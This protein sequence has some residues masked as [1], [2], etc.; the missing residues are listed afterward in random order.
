MVN[1]M[2]K[3]SGRAQ[4][5]SGQKGVGYNRLQ[6]VLIQ[7]LRSNWLFEMEVE[8]RSTITLQSEDGFT[9]QKMWFIFSPS[10]HQLSDWH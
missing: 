8:F 9:Q 5:T 3:V 1:G 10:T 4:I 7:H 6:T 2:F